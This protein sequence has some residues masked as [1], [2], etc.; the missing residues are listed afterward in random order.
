MTV[1][2]PTTRKPSPGLKLL[3]DL[4]P[5]AAFFA[6]YALGGLM[7]ATAVL[8]GATIAVLALG[9]AV[10]RR[11]ARMPL[12]T[13]VVVLVLGGL[14]LWLKDE[15]FIKRKPTVVYLAFAAVLLIGQMMGRSPLKSLLQ[16]ALE[17]SEDGWRRLTLRWG[18]FFIAMAAFNEVLWRSVST[19]MWVKVKVFGF[20]GLTLAFGALQ[21]PLIRRTTLAE[22]TPSSPSDDSQRLPK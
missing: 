9:Y 6:A 18:F 17:L 7:V 12:I 22:G 16:L 4:G 3:I 19:D 13:A 10:E 14:T 2:E 11:I 20:L 15:T 21:I 5:L 1:H 8:M